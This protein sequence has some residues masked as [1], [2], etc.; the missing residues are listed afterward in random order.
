M[1]RLPFRRDGIKNLPA[2]TALRMRPVDMWI[3]TASSS[4]DRVIRFGYWARMMSSVVLMASSL[5]LMLA[6]LLVD[7]CFEVIQM[8]PNR[9]AEADNADGRHGSTAGQGVTPPL[10]RHPGHGRCILDG[11]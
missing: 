7:P 6:F 5:S 10:L 1:I 8:Q 9:P 3:S 4:T 2:L 11:D